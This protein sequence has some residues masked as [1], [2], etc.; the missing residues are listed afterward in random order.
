MHSYPPASTRDWFQAACGHSKSMGAQVPYRNGIVQPTFPPASPCLQSQLTNLRLFDEEP[1][2]S[3]GH[4]YLGYAGSGLC[5]P[6]L[7]INYFFSHLAQ[8]SMCFTL[9]F[10]HMRLK[11]SLQPIWQSHFIHL[12]T[13]TFPLLLMLHPYPLSSN[14]LLF[15]LQEHY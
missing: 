9:H 4:L 8:F 1:A 15:T 6:L 12:L 13:H 10:S 3:A 5:P 11:L 2:N 7:S 14:Y